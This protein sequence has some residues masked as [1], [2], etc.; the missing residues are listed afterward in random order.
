MLVRIELNDD[1]RDIAK[2]YPEGP[3]SGKPDEGGNSVVNGIFDLISFNL[4]AADISQ[5][6]DYNLSRYAHPAVNIDIQVPD[7]DKSVVMSWLGGG[8]GGSAPSET[9]VRR[10]TGAVIGAIEDYFTASARRGFFTRPFRIGAAVINSEG[11]LVAVGAPKL[12]SPATMA[13]LMLVREPSVSGE[14]FHTVTEIMNSPMSLSLSVKP[15]EPSNFDIDLSGRFLIFATAQAQVLS[16]EE[17]VTGIRSVEVFG[18]R[19]PAWNYNRLAE[20]IVLQKASSGHD[21][22]VIAELPLSEIRNGV[23]A[24]KLPQNGTDLTDWKSFPEFENKDKLEDGMLP[25]RIIVTTRPLDLKKPEEYKKVRGVT[26]RGVFTRE[27]GN[28]GV[29]FTLY[30]S[31]HRERWHMVAKGQGAHIR[32]L[33]AI[34]YRWYKIEIDAPYGSNFE[35][36]TF[37]IKA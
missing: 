3:D 17:T 5:L 35:A 9:L 8:T 30:G 22:R 27:T 7:G 34:S 1:N 29:S 26:L 32:L 33:R 21:F 25:S 12:I 36:I 2:I 23:S 37:E 6:P 15:F 14:T 19:A 18:E 4:S 10:M 13:P 16:G 31:H 28:E 20:D 24:F 11:S